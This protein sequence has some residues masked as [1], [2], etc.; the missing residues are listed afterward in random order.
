MLILSFLT[1]S[2]TFAQ[3][4][5]I[6]QDTPIGLSPTSTLY[7]SKTESFLSV[8]EK[9]K[10]E[11]FA[12]PSGIEPALAGNPITKGVQ[13]V[14]T[15]KRALD[16][17][18]YVY[19]GSDRVCGGDSVDLHATC[20]VGTVVWYNSATGTEIIGT[21]AVLNIAPITNETYYA[22]C[23]H[24]FQTSSRVATHEVVILA[25]PNMPINVH[26]NKTKVCRGS[27]VT[28][29]GACTD[30][31]L[32]WYLTESEADS[33]GYGNSF[34][35]IPSQDTR[36][37]AACSN[38]TCVTNR[39]ATDS[40]MVLDVPDQPTQVFADRL[41]VCSRAVVNMSGVCSTGAST[42][43][44]SPIGGTVLD[45]GTQ[46]PEAT[47]TYY[48]VCVNQMCESPRVPTSPV[49]VISQPELPTYV[50]ANKTSICKGES[51]TLTASCS[52]GTAT[53]YSYPVGGRTYVGRGNSI[54][55]VPDST[56]TYF[57][58]CENDICVSERVR[59]DEV[60]VNN[61]PSVPSNVVIDKTEV[62]GGSPVSL[63][64]NFTAGTL[65]WY[66]EASGGTSIGSGNNLV[67]NP[68]VTTTYYAACETGGCTSVRVASTQLLVKPKP[69]KPRI[70]GITTI[71]SGESIRLI[72]TT[73]NANGTY[74]W[75]NGATGF[76]VDV[77]PT[78][79]TSYQVLVKENSCPSDS[80]DAFNI[81]VNP[82]P[83]PPG[84]TTN[85]PAICKGGSTLITGE[86]ANAADSFYWSTPTQNNRVT[87]SNKN[88][89]MITEPG[90]YKGWS[91]SAFGCRSNEA[92]IT[93]LQGAN[94]NGQNFITITPEKPVICPNTTV[95]LTASGCSGTVT[96]MNGNST[97]TG[98][99]IKV[100]PSVTT[101]YIINCSTGGMTNVDVVVANTNVVVTNNVSTG[102]ERM[103]A[104]LALES[105]RKI[106]DPDYT[107]APNVSFE[108]GRSILLKPG[109]VAEKYS[110]FKAEIRGCE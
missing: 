102:V 7:T 63:S 24:D 71:C 58:S 80:S 61:H 43:Y 53:W 32:V 12:V 109:F 28:L 82:K 21:G 40:V 3:Y 55:F 108:A 72:A 36:Y 4:T 1:A 51:V 23:D 15:K 70:S 62:C 20:Y 6:V 95:M 48:C 33:M 65:K 47:T 106:G 104:I 29:T 52:I 93:I 37:F 110:T 18:M 17:P 81:I 103:K 27:E 101:S 2:L 79:N 100:S 26:I 78:A 41:K 86:S 50:M 31:T 76:S 22:A 42:W 69:V 84:I 44:D 11:A 73:T 54:S 107:P 34:N 92:S 87:S 105:S 19:A 59:T 35:I 74:Y 8:D 96:W 30:G 38:G 97:H 56:N 45:G 60:V 77:S 10:P 67:H 39:V 89:R 75:S 66:T 99:Y 64:A 5:N 90:I 98:T 16:A 46:S 88:I 85:N 57:A 94:C 49:E 9:L 91:E 25:K 83:A 68:L 13:K 14:N